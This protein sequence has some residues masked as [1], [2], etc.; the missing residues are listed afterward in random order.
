VARRFEV[1]DEMSERMLEKL[2]FWGNKGS[3]RKLPR[4]ILVRMSRGSCYDDLV[5]NLFYKVNPMLKM[6]IRE[7]N[8]EFKAKMCVHQVSWAVRV[9]SVGDFRRYNMINYRDVTR[10]R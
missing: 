9:F 8:K 4:K 7:T 6:L 2:L 3:L 10:R 1:Y 5:V